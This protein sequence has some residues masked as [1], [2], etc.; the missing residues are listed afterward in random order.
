LNRRDFLA[1]AAFGATGVMAQCS[2]ANTPTT[3]PHKA[4]IGIPSEALLREWKE[5]GFE[6]MESTDHGASPAKAAAAR[7]IAEKVGMRI[8]SVMYGWANFNKPSAVAG[9]RASV[10]N[11][12]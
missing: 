7:K 4:L 12:L 2:W 10:E 6:G 1:A 9:G 3:Q 11:A 5:A 8:H